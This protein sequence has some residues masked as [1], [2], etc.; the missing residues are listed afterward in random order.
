MGARG[1]S[2]VGRSGRLPPAQRR[3]HGRESARNRPGK[4][5]G[6]EEG[7]QAGTR[8]GTLAPGHGSV[9]LSQQQT[10][11]HGLHRVPSSQA[12][13]S[14]SAQGPLCTSPPAHQSPF[15]AQR[16]WEANPPSPPCHPQSSSSCTWTPGGRSW[17]GR[18]AWSPGGA[19]PQRFC[20]TA[21]PKQGRDRRFGKTH[22]GI[23][24]T[25]GK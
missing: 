25:S 20:S 2:C 10:V 24:T 19:W 22:P 6:S 14:F 12:S 13:L 3:E 1:V 8:E 9:L 16:C 11:S 4:A 18:E 15:F 17:Q 7:L 21:R 23:P 5:E